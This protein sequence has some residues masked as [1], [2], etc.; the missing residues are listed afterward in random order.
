[1]SAPAPSPGGRAAPPASVAGITVATLTD[2][3]AGTRTDASGTS[4]IALPKSDVLVLELEGGHRVIA[5]PSGTEP[6]L[7]IYFDVRLPAGAPT[8][9]TRTEG[10]A[11]LARLESAMVALMT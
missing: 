3:L 1:L 2:C 8:T 6:K 9:T 11:L 10:E 7:K 4:P 5:R